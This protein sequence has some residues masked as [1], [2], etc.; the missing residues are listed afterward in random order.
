M[1]NGEKIKATFPHYDIEIDEHKGYVRVFC[2]DFYT[3]YPLRWWDAEYKELIDYKAR[4]ESR[5]KI[6]ESEILISQLRTDRDRLLE[7]LDKIKENFIARY[8]RNYAGGLELGG[9]SCVFSLNDILHTIDKY[10]AEIEPQE[11]EGCTK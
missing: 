3:T 4:F 6:A 7:V 1:T 11:G 10:K 8:P 9:R 2:E 5:S